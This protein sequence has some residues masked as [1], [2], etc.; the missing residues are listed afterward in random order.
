MPAIP[1]NSAGHLRV[2]TYSNKT[3]PPSLVDPI[4]IN[5]S[6]YD[7]TNKLVYSG[8]TPIRISEGVYDFPLPSYLFLKPAS[9]TNPFNAVTVIVLNDGSTESQAESITVK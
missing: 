7:P 2:F 5:M 3:I 1:L 4:S 9:F 6:L 8:N